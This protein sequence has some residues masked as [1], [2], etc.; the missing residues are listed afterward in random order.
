M[1]NLDP[2][3]AKA[4]HTSHGKLPYDAHRAD[5]VHKFSMWC[6]AFCAVYNLSFTAVS[7]FTYCI[8]IYAYQN[9]S[10]C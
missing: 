5:R 2:D 10:C 6:L 1:W 4:L 3:K 7:R 9:L 8:Y